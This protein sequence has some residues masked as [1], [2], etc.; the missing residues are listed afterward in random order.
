MSSVYEDNLFSTYDHYSASNIQFDTYEFTPAYFLQS[1]TNRSTYGEDSTGHILE[2]NSTIVVN[3]IKRPR[4]NDLISFYEPIRSNEIF[5][6]ISLS[7]PS[8]LLHSNPTSEWFELELEYA[9]IENTKKL[10]F[11]NHYVYDLSKEK[12]VTLTEYKNQ[13]DLL[14]QIDTLLTQI[15]NSYYNLYQDI[16]IVPVKNEFIES[17]QFEEYSY[18]IP[19]ALNDLIYKIKKDYS[20]KFKRLIEKCKSPYGFS[21]HTDLN[22]PYYENNPLFD[23]NKY[24]NY[25]DTYNLNTKEIETH[26]WSDLDSTINELEK[27]FLLSYRLSQLFDVV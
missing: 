1:V 4:I 5:R 25:L 11:L 27:S 22:M 20:Y 9:P 6:V 2:G 26:Y 24:D 14:D 19:I 3:T 8:N 17:E 16:Y 10:N 13:V 7:T 23:L 15:I 18:H 12:Y 21:Q